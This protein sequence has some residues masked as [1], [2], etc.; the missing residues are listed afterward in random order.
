MNEIDGIINELKQNIRGTY[1]AIYQG[2]R[3]S[4]KLFKY[5]HIL[6]DQGKVSGRSVAEYETF[7]DRNQGKTRNVSIPVRKDRADLVKQLFDKE[8]LLSTQA[9]RIPAQHCSYMSCNI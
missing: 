6:S 7:L 8:R 5:L 4:L 2:S 3:L 1:R 9:Y